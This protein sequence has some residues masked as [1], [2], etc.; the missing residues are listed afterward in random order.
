MGRETHSDFTSFVGESCETE[1]ALRFWE[2]ERGEGGEKKREQRRAFNIF[3]L[4]KNLKL[5]NYFIS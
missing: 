3:W 1:R 4:F 5:N 2:N